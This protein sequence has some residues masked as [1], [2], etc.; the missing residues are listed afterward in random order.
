SG[1]WCAPPGPLTHTH[2]HPLS[3]AGEHS[4]Y[5][6]LSLRLPHTFK[7]R[8]VLYC[9][10]NETWG[11][12]GRPFEMTP[13]GAS[14]TGDAHQASNACLKGSSW[15]RFHGKINEVADNFFYRLGYRVA[16]NPKRTLLISFAFVAACCFGFANFT[17]EADGE[18]LWVPADSLARDH[19]SIVL[20]DFGGDGEFASFLVESPSGSVLTKESVDA[21]WELDAIVMAVEAGGNTYA[22]VC[23]KELDGVTCEPVFRG[24]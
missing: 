10:K 24:I 23:A 21:I 22:D 17:I 18:D 8:C 3:P 15:S 16:T 9:C 2:A 14:S 20:E 13:N 6:P 11:A 19:Q 4:L 12:E 5:Y 1:S 7:R